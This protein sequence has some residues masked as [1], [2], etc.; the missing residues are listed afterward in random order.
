MTA[1]ECARDGL[2]IS[3]S[4]IRTYLRCPRSYLLRYVLGV[5]PAFKPVPFAFGT[6]FHAALA[7]FYVAVKEDGAPPPLQ[8]VT[9]A[10]RDAWQRELDADVRLQAEDDEPADTGALVDKGAEMLAVFHD[11]AVK[12][13]DGVK[14][15]AVEQ[16]FT[17]PL[18]DPDT[19]LEMEEKLVGALDLVLKKGRRRQVIEHKTAAQRYGEDQIRWDIQP[20]G[21]KLAARAMGLGEVKVTY[22]IV[23]K[24]KCPVLQIVDLDRNEEDEDE[25]Q[26]VAVNVMR[27]V[28]GGAFPPAR[29][30]ACRSCPY[31]HACRPPRPRPGTA[32]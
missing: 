8:L 26:R 22:Q 23:T 1:I 9:E 30:W 2:H 3:V 21:Y 10:F 28:D 17:I 14:V 27:G 24:A 7:R 16:P 12:S 11:Q 4:Q 31:S 19:G 29:S 6:S 5:A 15:E 32:G 18:F 13:L 20:T 25:F